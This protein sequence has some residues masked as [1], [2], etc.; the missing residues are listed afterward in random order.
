M[1]H[2]PV[3]I[4]GVGAATPLGNTYRDIAERLLAGQS[5]IRRIDKFDV[6]EHPAQIGAMVGA[7]ACP[8]GWDEAISPG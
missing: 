6:S 3:W 2:A 1:T 7:I 4:T 5:G 8:A